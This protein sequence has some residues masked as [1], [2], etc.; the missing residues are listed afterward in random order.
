MLKKLFNPPAWSLS[1]KISGIV[2]LVLSIP[3]VS[4]SLLQEIEKTLVQNLRDNLGLSSQLI[5]SQLNSRSDWFKESLL[6]NSSRF[7]GQEL[8]VFP[9]SDSF[10]LDGYFDDW[11]D[12]E[13]HRKTF[14][15]NGVSISI[16]LGNAAQNFILSIASNDKH[17]IFPRIENDT[18]SDRIEIEFRNDKGVIQQLLLAPSG[19]G[20][21]AVKTTK[22]G[23]MRHDWRYKAFWNNTST[24]FDVELRFPSNLR[25]REIKVTY[26]S[27][28]NQQ[29]KIYSSVVESSMRDLNPVVW[30][31]REFANYLNSI[32]LKP[33]QRI[34]LLD[35]YGRVLA[36]S[37]SLN[38]HGVEFSRNS[39]LNWFLAGQ[40]EIEVDPRKDQLHLDSEDIYRAF[41][42]KPSTRVE[43]VKN[44]DNA[45]AIA[46][47]PIK[48]SGQVKG[49]LLL[50]ENVAKVQVL[51]KKTLVKIF[52]TIVIVFILV[53][54]IVFWYVNR[55]VG[56]IKY[57]NEEIERVVDRQGRMRDSLNLDVKNGDEIDELYRAFSHMGDRL[58]EYNEYLEKLAA[59]LSHELRTP[60]AIVRSSLDNLLLNEPTIENKVLIERAMSGND[61]LGDIIARMKQASGVKEA[62]QSAEKEDLELNAF[63][64]KMIDG[65]QASFSAFRFIFTPYEK[66]ITKS[67]ST[68]LFC[69]MVDKL[70]ANAMDF[71]SSNEPILINLGKENNRLLLSFSNSS[72][73]IPKKNLKRIFHSLVS[74]RTTEQSSG[75]NLGLG[76]YVVRLISEFHGFSVTAKNRDDNTGVVIKIYLS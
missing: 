32:S 34:W 36:S 52:G 39:F 31:S 65:Y 2:L 55:T 57:L 59:R 70:I 13:L 48:I 26:K 28:S 53:V 71:S 42:G 10:T 47:Y 24:G 22:K 21:F 18:L 20:E 41:K 4:L 72:L 75:N 11:N 6:P 29:E 8:F 56:R 67:I 50:E 14:E 60:I 5:A 3:L 17:I 16:L 68:D 66:E 27:V 54:W 45:V 73:T 7:I 58:F 9:L 40:S 1:K 46:T 19:A 64:A 33:A 62:M 63:V 15:K 44:S 43:P 51:Q 25:P 37:G 74:I 35:H 38:N 61:R 23:I 49:V 30:P 12:H 76:L 69:E